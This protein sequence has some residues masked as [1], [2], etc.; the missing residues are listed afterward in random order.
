MMSLSKSAEPVL[1]VL[2]L[3][4]LDTPVLPQHLLQ[5]QHLLLHRHRHHATVDHTGMVNNASCVHRPTSGTVTQSNAW[6]AQQVQHTTVLNRTAYR[7]RHQVQQQ[8]RHQRWVQQQRHATCP[9]T[10]TTTRTDVRLVPQAPTM[11]PAL[12]H[13]APVHLVS[14][15]ISQLT[16]VS[17]YLYS[18]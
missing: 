14:G 2:P 10:G 1:L 18:Y 12:A 8:Q 11:I 6:H 7:H 13:V 17:D 3:T 15:L 5:H 9:T 16:P 4:S